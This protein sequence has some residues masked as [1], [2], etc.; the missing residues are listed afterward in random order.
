MSAAETEP[1][2]L[3][4]SSRHRAQ[5]ASVNNGYPDPIANPPPQ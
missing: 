1:A 4:R 5:S 3:V 2:D